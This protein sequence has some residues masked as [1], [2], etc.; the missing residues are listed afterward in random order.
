MKVKGCKRH[1]CFLLSQEYICQNPSFWDLLKWER[2]VL[3][4]EEKR[5][6]KDMMQ[7]RLQGSHVLIIGG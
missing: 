4:T 6:S 5:E 3:P 1:D 2:V 7:V